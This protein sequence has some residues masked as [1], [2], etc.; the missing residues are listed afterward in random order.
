MTSR[1]VAASSPRASGALHVVRRLGWG[2]VDQ[3]V[4]S[5]SNFALGLLVARALGPEGFGAFTLAYVT[6]GVVLNAARGLATDPLLVRHSGAKTPEWRRAVAA[7]TAT[8]TMVGVGVGAIC[9]VVGLLLP[10]EVGWGFVAL[11]VMLP[12]LMLQD[13]W[14]FAFFSAGEPS[15][16][17]VNDGLWAALQL[18]LVAVLLTTDSA[19]VFTCVLAFGGAA[20]ASAALGLL[21]TGI[22]PHLGSARTW[23]RT[24]LDLGGRYMIEN[25]SISG[26]RQV[27][28][29]LLGGIVDL[30]A[31][32]QVRAAEML[33]GPFLVILMGM[34]QVAVP[35]AAHV[36]RTAPERLGRF[37]LVFGSAQALAAAVW[38]ALVLIVL[39]MALGEALLGKLWHPAAALLPAVIAGMVVGGF[40]VGASAGVRALGAAR[41]S[42]RAQLTF[43]AL[44]LIGGTVGALMG[45]AQGTCIGV[46]IATGLGSI[47]WWYQLQRAR[48]EYAEAHPEGPV[49][50]TS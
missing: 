26:A 42:L 12:G 17:V 13:A 43:A 35:E 9:V 39:P 6:Y 44:Y 8:G 29:I 50:E 25:V 46:A 36:L 1:P 20:L 27:R 3:G 49:G 7:S 34:S 14:R 5:I 38:G 19:T 31:V 23:V 4:S 18:V 22:R 30:A 47:V 21:Q 11:G 41:R 32:G 16:A 48:A 24:N 15:K 2:V 40:E 10:H 37:C 33:M 28:F 45:G